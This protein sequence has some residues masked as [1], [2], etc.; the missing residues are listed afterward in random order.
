MSNTYEIKV[1]IKG[2]NQTR[3][4]QHCVETEYGVYECKEFD[5]EEEYNYTIYREGEIFE[6]VGDIFEST[7]NYTWKFDPD[8]FEIRKEA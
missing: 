2:V 8:T 6:V 5:G 4:F 7:V 1:I 3:L